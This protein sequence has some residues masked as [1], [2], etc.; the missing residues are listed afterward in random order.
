MS[1][2]IKNVLK[3]SVFTLADLVQVEEGRVNSLT[4]SQTPATKV[5]LFA[6]DADE[7]MSSHAAGGDAM[8]NVLEGT[9]E[10][11]ING[12]AHEVGAG[13]SIVIPAGAPHSVRGVTAFKML[14]VVVFA[15]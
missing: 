10:I 14:L 15:S 4:L 3:E 2:L 7:G 5:T 1:E 13:Q 9:S 11:T 12:V 6:I 8:V